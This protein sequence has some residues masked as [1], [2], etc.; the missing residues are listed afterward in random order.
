[1]TEA[2]GPT[3]SVQQVTRENTPNLVLKRMLRYFQNIP[4]LKKILQF[5]TKIKQKR[6]LLQKRKLQTR[7]YSNDL[8]D[9]LYQ[10]ET[11]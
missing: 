11:N 1:M 3:N 9:E 7:N 10:L 5:K 8:P 4:P 2:R 6:K